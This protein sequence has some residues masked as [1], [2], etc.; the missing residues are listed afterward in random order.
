MS[1]ATL[2]T[3]KHDF[4]ALIRLVRNGE[5][6]ILTDYDRPVARIVPEGISPA[7]KEEY[8][9]KLRALRGILKRSPSFEREPDREL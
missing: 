3:A 8:L 7:R 6:V 5:E 2:E 1:T 9:R 4:D